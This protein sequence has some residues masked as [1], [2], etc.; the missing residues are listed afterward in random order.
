[1]QWFIRYIHTVRRSDVWLS[2][3]LFFLRNLKDNIS[4][5]LP[6]ETNELPQQDQDLLPEPKKRKYCAFCPSKIRRMT[7]SACYKCKS[8]MCGEH[9]LTAC[10]NCLE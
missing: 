8:P 10:S 6:Q 9:K 4:A 2:F 7:K 3:V 1:M 5:I